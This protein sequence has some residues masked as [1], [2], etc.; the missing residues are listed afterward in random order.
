MRRV[1]KTYFELSMWGDK[2]YFGVITLRNG[3][4]FYIGP[5]TNRSTARRHAIKR[6]KELGV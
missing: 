5:F 3:H 6:M 1:P 2:H 4:I